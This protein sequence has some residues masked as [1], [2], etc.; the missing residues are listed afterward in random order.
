M[1]IVA[2]IPARGGSERI[3]RK[4][5]K[6]LAGH[7]LLAYA[8]AGAKRARIFDGIYVST[9]DP[10][11]AK[12]AKR[13]GAEVIVRPEILS[14]STG[15]DLQWIVHA[16]KNVPAEADQCVLL[17]PTNP[18]RTAFT[19]LR[20]WKLWTE[21]QPSDSLRSVREVKETPFKMWFEPFV[22]ARIA[23]IEPIIHQ[24]INY[25]DLPTQQLPKAYVQS[26]CIQI[27]TRKLVE[28]HNDQTGSAVVPFY[29]SMSEGLD[30]NH[31]EDWDRA[32]DLLERGLATLEVIE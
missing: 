14:L 18:C 25:Y 15:T 7:P 22:N 27:F 24:S 21:S 13:Y 29:T 2:F 32:N 12:V 11:V 10:E 26:G 28:E 5:I 4:N 8:I 23:R 6:H 1:S 9:E 19:I 20:A 31:I 16:L 30:L 3:K 17:R